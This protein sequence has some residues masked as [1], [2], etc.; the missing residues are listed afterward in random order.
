[1]GFTFSCAQDV[2]AD[3]VRSLTA[4]DEGIPE[5][6]RFATNSDFF[7]GTVSELQTDAGKAKLDKV[8]K[9]KGVADK[10]GCDRAAL[11]LAWTL[12]NENVR[13][14]AQ[15]PARFVCGTRLVL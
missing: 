2:K 7:K 12:K 9:L 6:S 4:D 8:R 11:A 10:L 5:D 13:W 14:V 1:M 3:E 15:S